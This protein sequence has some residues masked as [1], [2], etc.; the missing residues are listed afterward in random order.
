MPSTKRVDVSDLYESPEG[1][2]MTWSGCQSQTVRTMGESYAG[3]VPKGQEVT[4][5]TCRAAANGGG[6]EE[7]DMYT[8]LREGNPGFAKGVT[9]CVIT[10][11]A[12]VVAA[13]VTDMEDEND[14]AFTFKVSTLT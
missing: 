2:D 12:R 4:K 14:Y 6:L 5:D 7:V 9:M 10:D 8:V 11:Q 1:V 13:K 3:L